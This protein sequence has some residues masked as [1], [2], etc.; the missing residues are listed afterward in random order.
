MMPEYGL[1]P[2]KQPKCPFCGVQPCPLALQLTSFGPAQPAVV[3]ICNDCE[4]ILSVA[5][6]IAPVTREPQKERAP[7]IMVPQ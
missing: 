2:T 4:R 3:F 5:P 6:L 7:L 1:P